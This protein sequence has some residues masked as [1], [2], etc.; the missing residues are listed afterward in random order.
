MERLPGVP[1][2]GGAPPGAGGRLRP[3]V[4]TG[5]GGEYFRIWIVNLFL[6]ILSLAVYSAWAKVRRQRYF[7]RNTRFAGSAFDYHARPAA[8]LVGRIFAIA[9][10]AAF[11]VAVELQP[12]AALGLL[13]AWLLGL[14][15]IVH[16]A[17][18]FRHANTS[19]RGIR[20]GFLGTVGEA[21]RALMMPVVAW[22]LVVAAAV[23]LAWRYGSDAALGLVLLAAAA[24]TYALLP[25]LH[26]RLRRYH[27]D[28]ACLGMLPTRFSA[29]AG[30]FYGVYLR[31]LAL[32]IALVVGFL[33]L[34]V[35][36]MVAIGGVSTAIEVAATAPGGAPAVAGLGILAGAASWFAWMMVRPYFLARMQN[37]VW[38]RTRIGP[39]RFVSR[40]RMRRLWAI[41]MS[42]FLLVLATLGLFLPFAKVRLARYRLQ[43]VEV[44]VLGDLDRIEG[45]ERERVSAFGEEAA[46][47]FDLDI[48]I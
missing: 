1:P 33:A 30:M 26:Y 24:G 29:T 21:Y 34:L 3:I 47:L 14:P 45:G 27:H 6:S 41:R 38:N 15:W 39:H 42:N 17:L 35:G 36:T 32:G 48:G 4:F 11:V 31:S 7:H 2:T 10:L 25:L 18:R 8:I 46:D 12:L 9:G 22:M 13:V 5:S 37:L 44:A 43:S 28:N 20:F 19:W 23:G 16:R 40:V